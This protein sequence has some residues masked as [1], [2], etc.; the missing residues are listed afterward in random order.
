MMEKMPDYKRIYTDILDTRFPHKKKD[1]ESILNKEVLSH[2]DVIDLN[3]I[4]YGAVTAENWKFDKR[5]RSYNQDT[6]MEILQHQKKNKLSNRQL[7]SHYKL[8]RNTVAR[9]KKLFVI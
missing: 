2:L 6:I 9:W 1:C 5:H 8:S 7:A 4:I 3:T